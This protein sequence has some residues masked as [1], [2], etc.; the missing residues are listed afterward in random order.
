[1]TNHIDVLLADGTTGKLDV[2]SLGINAD[3]N[4]WIGEEVEIIA[5]DENGNTMRVTGTLEEVL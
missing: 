5:K 3:L 4:E 1:M 2:T